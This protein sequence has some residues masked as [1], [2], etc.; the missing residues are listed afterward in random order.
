MSPA[1]PEI[2]VNCAMSIDGR[3]AL[4]GGRPL[5]LS[6]PEDL[7]RVHRMRSECDAIVVGVGTVISD[8][9]SLLV[10][11]EL[12]GRPSGRDP[13][14]VVLD[15]TGRTPAEA[16]ILDGTAP[17]LVAVSERSRRTFPAPV[18]T[19]VVGARRVELDRLWS[20][21][22]ARGAHRV[23]VE[24]GATVLAGVLRSGRFD[25]LSVYVAPV[26]VGGRSAPSLATGEE[27]SGEAGLTRLELMGVERL[28]VGV[29]LTYGPGAAGT[30]SPGRSPPLG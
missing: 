9:P 25:R 19:V 24:G 10:K 4:P 3:L 11:W 29:L 2:L 17:T 6:G 5:A 1:R 7:A 23:M 28:G 26:V 16:R 15:S 18:E 8:D 14:R 12:A 21:L 22:A 13:I 27:P 30:L 20:A